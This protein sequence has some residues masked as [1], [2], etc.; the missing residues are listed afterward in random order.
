MSVRIHYFKTHPGPFGAV[1]A[2][3]KPYEIRRDDRDHRPEVGDLV[4]LQE[5]RPGI[6]EGVAGDYTGRELRARVTYVSEP[7]SWGLPHELYVFGLR[8]E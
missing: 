5:W 1:A 2:G 4:I 7:G 8:A 3:A 6:A